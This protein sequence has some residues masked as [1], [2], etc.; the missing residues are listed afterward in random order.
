MKQ[1]LAALVE[2]RNLTEGEMEA[3]VGVLMDGGATPA[4]TGAFL[5]ALRAKGETVDE[6]VATV[7]VVRA[8]SIRVQAAGDVIDTCGTGGDGRGTFNVSTAAAF[9]AA[10]GGAKV[11]KHGN[12]AASGKVGAADV[13]E[14][15]GARIELDAVDAARVLA[16]TGITFMFAPCFH[17]AFRH[18]GPVRKELGFRTLFNLT[19][20]LCN[21]AGARRQLLGL[22]SREAMSMVAAAL[23]RLGCEHALVVHGRDGSDEITTTGPSYVLEVRSDSV[24]EYEIAP[25]DF[26]IETV[27]ADALKGSDASGNAALIRRVLVGEVG[28]AGD[29]VALN[30][31]AALYV[32]GNALSIHEGVQSARALIADGAPARVLDAFVRATNAGAT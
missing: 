7:R 18:V 25:A 27:A 32:A 30:A 8:R 22:F 10:A 28:P 11:A 16:E 19:G 5:A 24:D 9:V 4:Q 1:V 13:L 14:A 20:P 26:G 6:L 12:R 15:L 23:Q 21:P 17:P 2:G 3:A 29:I 31:G